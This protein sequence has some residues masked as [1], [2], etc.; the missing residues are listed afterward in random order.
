[1]QKALAWAFK[2]YHI[3]SAN[4]DVQ[5]AYKVRRHLSN[6]AYKLPDAHD[7][8]LQAAV[9]GHIRPPQ[10]STRAHAAA[11]GLSPLPWGL[12]ETLSPELQAAFKAAFKAEGM[13][14]AEVTEVAQQLLERT[15]CT[16]VKQFVS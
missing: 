1:M 15:C 14:D 13:I 12:M 8:Q 5:T 11:L 7:R 6:C 3:I 10:F 2:S 4:R 16:G 9:V